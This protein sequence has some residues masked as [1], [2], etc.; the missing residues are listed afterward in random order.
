[1][2]NI[3]ESNILGGK[4]KS[5]TDQINFTS[6]HSLIECL[7]INRM[8]CVPNVII[9]IESIIECIKHQVAKTDRSYKEG[10]TSREDIHSNPVTGMYLECSKKSESDRL[11]FFLQATLTTSTVHSQS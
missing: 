1:M 6:F 10:H 11:Q 4:K 2:K 8:V 7:S 3:F 9:I 5:T